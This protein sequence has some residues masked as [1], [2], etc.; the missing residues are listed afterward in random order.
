MSAED[1]TPDPKQL[2]QQAL[3]RAKEAAKVKDVEG[4]LKELAQSGILDGLLR[5]LEFS[6][7]GN[8]I[9]PI[10]RDEIVGK[11]V[12][13]FYRRLSNGEEIGHV[14]GWFT[15]VVKYKA[16][17][18]YR[19]RQDE[20]G[21]LSDVDAASVQARPEN[22]PSTQSE[23]E[24][25]A[26]RDAR[27][28]RGLE[29]AR[30]LLPELSISTNIK[31]VM[32]YIFDAVEQRVDDLQPI[33]IARALGLNPDSVRKWIE[34]GFDRLAARAREKGYT[35]QEF[36]LAEFPGRGGDGDEGEDEDEE[37]LDESDG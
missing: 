12:D 26:E 7:W 8:L 30:G 20:P 16:A 5:R 3:E 6:D 9:H 14:S 33:D 21:Q 37:E 32:A 18:F 15:K 24:R 13:D 11:A 2:Q 23:E 28:K 25:E 1:S 4:M 19:E 10:D 34:R 22:R 27:R 31:R 29:L 17:D 35:T 36:N